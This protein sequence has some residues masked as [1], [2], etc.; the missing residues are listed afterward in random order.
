MSRENDE[1]LLE[2]CNVTELLKLAEEQGL[3]LL[4]AGR[5]RQRLQNIVLGVLDP[6]EEDACPTIEGRH[7]FQEFVEQHKD[8]T[9]NQLPHCHGACPTFGCP[10]GIVLNCYDENQ[11]HVE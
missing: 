5:P 3:G 10:L 2:D 6:E 8:V 9:Y 4:S 11:E 1:L 7:L